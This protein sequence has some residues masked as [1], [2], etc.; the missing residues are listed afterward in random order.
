MGFALLLRWRRREVESADRFGDPLSREAGLLYTNLLLIGAAGIVLVGTL[1]PSLV[2][3]VQQRQASLDA[4]FYERTVGPFLQVLVLLMGICPW[5]ASHGADG[6]RLGRWLLP[7]LAGALASAIVLLLAGIREA[8]FL[9]SFSICVFV[10]ICIAM[11][12]IVD[13]LNRR[14]RLGEGLTTAFARSLTRGRRLGAHLVHLGIVF[15]ALG[16]TGSSVYKSEVQV[17]LE[18]GETTLFR[19]Y[20]LTYGQLATDT[21]PE[22]ARFVAPLEIY[23]GGKLL[24]SLTPAKEYYGSTDQWVTEV[25][26]RSRLRE[27]LYVILAGFEQDGLASF[28]L[29]VNPLVIWIWIGGAVL[30]LGGCVAW[31]PGRKRVAP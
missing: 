27:D 26:I 25:A 2:A 5:L 31:A 28:R 4:S 8:L 1:S 7:G 19:G 29:L 12:F 24:S 3:L 10:V 30:L 21:N 23:R 18:P 13:A 11:V 20:N 6:A 9:I 17:A 22:R 14:R 15:I 16:I